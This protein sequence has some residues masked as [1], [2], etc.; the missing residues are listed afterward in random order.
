MSQYDGGGGEITEMAK[1]V[2]ET[3]KATSQALKLAEKVGPFIARIIGEPLNQISGIVTDKLKYIRWERSV[4]LV[5][6]A[7]ELMEQRGSRLA[8]RPV[9]MN[10]AFPLLEA[11]SLEEDDELQDI[12]ANLLVNAADGNSGIDVKRAL[13]SILQDFSVVEVRLLQAIYDAPA[14]MDAV[15]TKGLPSSYVEPGSQQE[16]PGLPDERVQI[17]L[18]QLKR[19]GCISEAGTWDSVFGIRRVRLTALGK[20]LV[21]ACSAVP[22]NTSHE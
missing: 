3:A 12:W 16:D 6:R 11:A 8:L 4:R 19:L 22:Q 10:V 13:V 14:H 1:A 15:P 18:W 20:T 21:E 7:Q 17:G 5:D 2:T 9:A